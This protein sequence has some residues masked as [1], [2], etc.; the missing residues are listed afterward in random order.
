MSSTRRVSPL[1][2]PVPKKINREVLALLNRTGAAGRYEHNPSHAPWSGGG[3]CKIRRQLDM[4][5]PNYSENRHST[6]KK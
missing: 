4:D 2:V 3:L 5:S 1:P 6:R